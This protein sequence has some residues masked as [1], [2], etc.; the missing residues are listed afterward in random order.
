MKCKLRT[1]RG[2]E[3]T[4]CVRPWQVLHQ[5]PL[6]AP[7]WSCPALDALLEPWGCVWLSGVGGVSAV[8][9]WASP[10]S[11]PRLQLHCPC[12]ELAEP[13]HFSC[14]VTSVFAS[15]HVQRRGP[16]V[17]CLLPPSNSVTSRFLVLLSQVPLLQDLS[18]EALMFAEVLRMPTVI[19]IYFYMQTFQKFL[20]TL[21]PF[22]ST[23]YYFPYWIF[24]TPIFLSISPR[25]QQDH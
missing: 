20:F 15:P 2:L 17:L 21:N 8:A 5:G 9:S 1:R 4:S 10:C 14:V 7:V 23:L 16:L 6:W 18:M 25:F 11:Q 13:G 24:L 22:L 12:A 19:D 3:V